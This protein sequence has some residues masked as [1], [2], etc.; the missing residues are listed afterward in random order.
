MDRRNFIYILG[1]LTSLSRYEGLEPRYP[2]SRRS[3][4]KKSWWEC[5]SISIGRTTIRMLR[6]PGRLKTIAATPTE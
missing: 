4:V 1:G 3:P 6:G 5:I 2:T